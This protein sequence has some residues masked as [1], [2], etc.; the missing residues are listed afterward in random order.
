MTC[1]DPLADGAG[2]REVSEPPVRP[3]RRFRPPRCIRREVQLAALDAPAWAA[4]VAEA[5]RAFGRTGV[6]ASTSAGTVWYAAGDGRGAI[7]LSAVP[8]D[9]GPVLAIQYAWPRPRPWVAA[10]AWLC[11]PTAA[12]VAVVLLSRPSVVGEWLAV[13]ALVAFPLAVAGVSVAAGW[14]RHGVVSRKAS[15]VLRRARYETDAWAEAWEP[16]PDDH[17]PVL[18]DPVGPAEWLGADEIE[19]LLDARPSRATPADLRRSRRVVVR[20]PAERAPAAAL[21]DGFTEWQPA[22][23]S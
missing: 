12:V 5:E 7:E 14:V 19:G 3:R 20:A 16:E 8:A 6:H 21:P 11:G 23:P 1:P 13:V 2:W 9:A 15:R 18:P 22:R 10:S 4:V 17:G